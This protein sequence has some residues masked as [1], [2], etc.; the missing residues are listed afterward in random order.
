MTTRLRWRIVLTAAVTFAISMFAWYPFLAAR[1]GLSSPGFLLEKQL[2]LGLDLKGGIHMVLRVNTDDAVLVETRNTAGRLDEA[3]AREG[4]RRGPISVLGPGQYRV[5]DVAAESD[6][7]F[8]RVSDELT[9]DYSR[10]PSP[11]RTYTFTITRDALESL[12]ENTVKQTQQTVERRVDELGVAEPVIAVQGAARDEIVVQLPG[13]ADMDRA[14]DILGATALLEWKLVEQGPSPT[15][16]ALLEPTGGAVPANTEVAIGGYGPAG[17]DGTAHY[18][19]QSLA[20]ITGRDLRNARSIPDEN[21]QPAVTFSL[22]PDAARRFAKFTGA[23]VGRSLAIILDGRVQSAPQIEGRIDRGEGSIRGRFTQREAADLSLVLRAG[24]LPASMTYLGGRLVG[25]SLGSASIHAGVVASVAGLSLIAAFMLLYY[26]RAGINALVSVAVNLLLLLGL[27]AYS[28][29]A[30]TLPGIAGLILT[31]GMGVDSNVLIF[32]RIKEELAAGRGAR[33][34]VAAGFDR[35]FLTIL[36]THIASLIAAAFLFQFGTGPIRGFATTLTFG[37]LANV[38]TA[39]FVSRTMFEAVISRGRSARLR[40]ETFPRLFRLPDLDFHRWRWHA[41]ALSTT[42]IVA[43]AGVALAR[44][45]VPLGIDFSGGTLVTVKFGQPVSEEVIQHAIPGNETVQRYGG[46][47]DNEVLIRLPQAEGSREGG[48]LAQEASR[49][50]AALRAAPVP[51]FEVTGMETV[52]PTIGADLRRK[53]TYATMA[54]LVG[55]AAYIAVR[56]RPSFAAGAIAATLHDIAVTVSLLAISGYDLSLNVVAAILTITGYSVND[57]IVTFDRARENLRAMPHASLE[58][59]VNVAVN[60]T[61]GR[62]IIT[63]GTTFLAVLALFVFGGD[64]LHGFAFAML[65][66]IVSGTYSTIFIAGA[67]AIALSR[68]RTDSVRR[69]R[70]RPRLDAS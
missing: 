9:R 26:N 12:R 47:A 19:V 33:A 55:I 56:F 37:L 60:Q 52:G 39:V 67:I 65:V 25:P 57:T 62:T 48:T 4:V 11:G 58:R 3:L 40:M 43:G 46:P 50:V 21:G 54:S 42:V 31:I 1:Y 70:V 41:L 23:H 24:A 32:E 63:A 2:K 45:G 64:V 15:R 44:G 51:P 53:G 30:L 14:R 35:V 6:A 69:A 13:V 17:A 22:T 5:P 29:A 36:D 8:R 16:E 68:R 20:A 34:A 49:A 27:M 10:E 66:G 61:L 59:A 38:F 18:L 7:M 28:Q